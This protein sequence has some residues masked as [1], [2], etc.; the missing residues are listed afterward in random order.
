MDLVYTEAFHVRSQIHLATGQW[1][2]LT[3]LHQWLTYSSLLAGR[4]F[5]EW[6]DRIIARSMGEAERICEDLGKPFLLKP[7]RMPYL[8]DPS[9]ITKNREM[10]AFD[11][12]WLPVVTCVGVFWGSP[13]RDQGKHIGILQ[14][15]WFQSAYA[16]PIEEPAAQQLRDL[17]WVNLA[18]DFEF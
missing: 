7:E 2:T 18:T 10:C 1:L 6:N 12:E 17:N 15:V 11:P 4:P 16:P 14:V 8:R 9:E 3:A 5:R 13:A